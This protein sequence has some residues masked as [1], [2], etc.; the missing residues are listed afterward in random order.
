M[1]E[2]E[3]Q[4]KIK[5]VSDDEQKVN[6]LFEYTTKAS[7]NSFF[8]AEIVY[9]LKNDEMKKKV[10]DMYEFND[11]V[12]S[13]LLKTF[14]DNEKKEIILKN[15][16]KLEKVY[17]IELLESLKGETIIDFINEHL[18]FINKINI[19]PFEIIR[20]MDKEEQIKV[21]NN[22][23]K[24]KLGEKDKLL[25]VASLSNDVKEKIDK[26]QLSSR[27][28]EI[29]NIDMDENKYYASIDLN[30]NLEKYRDLDE[31]IGINPT[32]LNKEEKE[33]FSKLCRIC[34][35]LRVKDNLI[36]G[37]STA[38]EYIRSED[39]IKS[40]LKEI[41]PNW[42]NVQKLAYIDNAIGKKI[43]YSPDCDT[44]IFNDST[45][46]ALW[47]V[48]DIGYGV[49]NGISQIE[50][51]MLEQV[52]IKSEIVHSKNH[53]FLIIKNIELPKN[54]G[55]TE[56]GDTIVDP[57]WNITAHKF[58]GMPLNFCINYE[59]ARKS[60]IESDGT[61]SKSHYIEPLKTIELDEKS[62]R[63][64]FTSIGVANK[65]GSFPIKELLDKS[66]KIYK[67]NI[68]ENEL[69]AK[70]F[71]LLKEYRPEF[72]KSINSTMKVLENVILDNN[73]LSYE[74]CI[75]N[76]V[77]KKSDRTKKP[78]LYIYM[79]LPKN[80]KKFYFL[81]ETNS[82][83]V[84]LN[85]QEFE[86]RFECYKM[87]LNNTNGVRPWEMKQS[88]T[89]KENLFNSSRKIINKEERIR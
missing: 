14:S 19:S 80:S 53:A 24:I 87:D 6:M 72:A 45:S 27:Y 16:Y 20:R 88:Q 32:K 34:P 62:L 31:L 44:E 41:K 26:K 69:L 13:E 36:W 79:S 1:T 21:V 39:W 4:T 55:L 30:A 15:K 54:D 51:Y 22:L 18:S 84:E 75:V 83:F 89:I 50:Q 9:S 29:L 2:F 40:V 61:D 33:K 67:E 5:E 57:T 38:Q 35:N 58:G 46:R 28:L 11:Y 70:Q 81:D 56:I 86:D 48:I 64:V 68:S 78:V 3:F 42:S 43:S 71:K 85:K 12:K 10:I 25:I 82:E 63:E 74:R 59:K 65:D 60:D 77:Y 17:I 47:K 37:G 73:K 23:K 66:K 76:R 52:G 49:C 7:I 8:I